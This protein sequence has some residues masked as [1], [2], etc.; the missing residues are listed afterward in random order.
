MRF[1]EIW[2]HNEFRTEDVYCNSPGDGHWHVKYGAVNKIKY[3]ASDQI[4][5][6]GIQ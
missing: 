1:R 2:D 6:W 5:I 3:L 4:F